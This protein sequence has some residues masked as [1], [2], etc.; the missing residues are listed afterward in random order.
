[1]DAH[2]R[3]YAAQAASFGNEAAANCSKDETLHRSHPIANLL[4]QKAPEA[5]ST[6]SLISQ[7]PTGSF[8]AFSLTF[9]LR[10][11]LATNWGGSNVYFNGYRRFANPHLNCVDI[12]LS[13]PYGTASAVLRPALRPFLCHPGCSIPTA[14]TLIGENGS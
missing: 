7:T 5:V 9:D 3:R 4:F 10:W 8:R 14:G 2:R 13:A 1:L 6:Y 11:R 12:S